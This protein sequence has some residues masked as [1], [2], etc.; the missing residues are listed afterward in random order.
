VDNGLH[1]G[2]N[3]V[4]P[5]AMPAGAAAVS[6]ALYWWRATAR[7]SWRQA[8]LLALLGG[9]LGSVALGAV[10][11]ARRTSTAY[12]RYLTSIKASDAVVNVPGKLP[13]EPVL[14]PIR[15]IAQRPGI[16]SSGT[17]LGLNARPVIHGRVDLSATAPPLNGSLDGEYFRQDRM[18]VLAGH[19]PPQSSSTEI[20]LAPRVARAFRTGVGRRLP[21]HSSASAAAGPP[22]R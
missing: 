7:R 13:A 21:T 5:G 15:L 18:T 11:G 2:G 9:L 3:A 17:Y 14:R 19:L 16:L 12:G 6:K 20:V 22:A 8:L 10:A 1:G 4:C